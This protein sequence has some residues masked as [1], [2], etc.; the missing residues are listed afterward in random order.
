M[1][2]GMKYIPRRTLIVPFRVRDVYRQVIA[3]VRP[4][5]PENVD[6]RIAFSICVIDAVAEPQP[7]LRLASSALAVVTICELLTQR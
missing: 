1:Y 3:A 6:N 7:T 2:T 5:L 4:R